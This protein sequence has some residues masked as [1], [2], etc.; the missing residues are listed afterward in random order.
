MIL[1]RQDLSNDENLRDCIAEFKRTQILLG[2]QQL[3]AVAVW[4][5]KWG[6]AIMSELES[7]T[8]DEDE[9]E[10]HAR[11]A[12]KP[13]EDSISEAVKELEKISRSLANKSSAA[14]AAASIDI[15]IIDL[16]KAI[17]Q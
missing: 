10:Y 5:N 15:I 14:K 2:Y 9:D 13:L 8:R 12:M 3:G 4:A 6:E 1:T 7:P 11:V 16:E 17:D